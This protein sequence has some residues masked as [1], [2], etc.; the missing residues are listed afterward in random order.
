MNFRDTMNCI[1]SNDRL[2]DCVLKWKKYNAVLKGSK[3]YKSDYKVTIS[4]N[5]E[6]IQ[7]FTVRHISSFMCSELSAKF[8]RECCPNLPG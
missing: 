5:V 7:L 2:A 1:R 8:S 6:L 4:V 3:S